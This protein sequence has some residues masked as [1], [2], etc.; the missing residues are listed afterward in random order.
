MPLIVDRK[1]RRRKVASVAFDLVAEQGIEAV[2]FRQV[3]GA[4]GTSTAIVSNW[5]DNKN[6]LLFEVYRIA[7]HRMMERLEAAFMQDLDI[8][9][10]IAVVLPVTEETRRTWLVWLAFWGRA[11]VEPDYMAETQR[12][13]RA[14]FD[15][16]YRMLAQRY[17]RGT[18][19][20][21]AKVDELS[22][23]LI[24]TVGGI[25]LQAVLAPTDW[26]LASLRRLIATELRVFDDEMA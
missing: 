16:Y 20:I 13:A 15:L 4:A 25:A 11:H 24:A 9:D 7:N 14:S 21:D 22:R 26:S 6:D 10:V 18:E 19:T 3:A 17:G 8:L 2:T 23:R 1:E 12:N 5:F